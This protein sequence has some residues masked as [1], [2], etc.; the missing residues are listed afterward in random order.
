MQTT[1]PVRLQD[2]PTYHSWPGE[3]KK[4]V[5]GEGIYIGYRHYERL[6]IKPLFP[7][8]HGLSYTTFYYSTITLSSPTLSANEKLTVSIPITNTGKVDGAE[9][10][11][12]Y[13]HDVKSRIARPE[14]EL[15]AF[16]KIFLKA[17]ETKNVVLTLDKYSL[18]YYDT[19]LQAW[20]AEEGTF[21]ILV[22][23]SSADIRF[24]VPLETPFPEH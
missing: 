23:S 9:V 19:R 16:E 12:G 21:M 13:V 14:K 10:V 20:T 2:N 4:V 15:A 11:Q 24:V 8:G 7:F 1:F 17:G 6:A 18:G 22:G 5:Y 3:N